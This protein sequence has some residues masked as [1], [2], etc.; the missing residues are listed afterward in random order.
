MDSLLLADAYGLI[1]LNEYMS[2][3]TESYPITTLTKDNFTWGGDIN[4]ITISSSIESIEEETFYNKNLTSVDFS[5]AKN[6]QY[7]GE[8]A[9][10]S[11]DIVTLDLSGA[12]KLKSLGTSSFYRNA[13]K[14][15]I[16]PNSVSSIASNAFSSN[17]TLTSITIDN[18]E[19]S[20][21]YSPWGA[22]NATITY[23]R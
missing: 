20:I 7:I 18:S 2:Y 13:L 12:T 5:N 9:F 11:N 14:S 23:L 3:E 4:S 10:K 22:T 19:G 21:P 17:S 6:L 8:E 1:Y 15:V 16:I